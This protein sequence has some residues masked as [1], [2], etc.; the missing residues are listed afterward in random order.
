MIQNIFFLILGWVTLTSSIPLT[1]IDERNASIVESHSQFFKNNLTLVGTNCSIPDDIESIGL[2]Y[3]T[4]GNVNIEKARRIFLEG[5]EYL[6]TLINNDQLLRPYLHD[7][8]ATNKNISFSIRWENKNRE[9]V[10]QDFVTYAFLAK[11]SI[12]YFVFDKSKEELVQ[13]HEENYEEAKKLLK[14]QVEKI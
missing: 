11:G 9:W 10:N 2:S 12:F 13:I 14:N 3:V 5:S 7:Y 6:I 4:H 1:K 8:P